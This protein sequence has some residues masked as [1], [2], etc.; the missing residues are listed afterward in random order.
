MLP[1]QGVGDPGC[2]LSSGVFIFFDISVSWLTF[3]LPDSLSVVVQ[4][5][6]R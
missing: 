1:R 2:C 6:K 5:K 3:P 4:Q